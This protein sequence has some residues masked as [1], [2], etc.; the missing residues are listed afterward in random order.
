MK[1]IVLIKSLDRQSGSSSNFTTDSTLILE[2]DYILKYAIIPNTIFNVNESNRRVT[3][4]EGL[5]AG[6]SVYPILLP[7]GNYTADTFV[8]ML[9]TVLSAVSPFNT[10]LATYDPLTFQLTIQD[11]TLS[12][13]R[14]DLSASPQVRALLG[15]N[16]MMTA[17]DTQTT[18][19]GVLNLGSPDS[20]GIQVQ[21]SET[22]GFENVATD[23]CGTIYVPLNKTF[24]SYQSLSSLEL[25]QYVRFNQRQRQLNIRVVDTS[26][27]PEVDL[28]GSNFELLLSKV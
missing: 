12:I 27:N 10:Y 5:I 18:G 19:T 26:T 7:V 6:A 13:F 3:L 4:L 28:N 23:T 11:Q 2:G 15:F 9:S 20:L 17:L 22:R 8:D 14:L 24:G 25:P 21:Q 16:V 1:D